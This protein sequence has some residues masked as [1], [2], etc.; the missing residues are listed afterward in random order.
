MAAV[1]EASLTGR[2]G[3]VPWRAAERCLIVGGVTGG[4]LEAVALSH[5]PL[6]QLD[7]M[8]SSALA[9]APGG[10]ARFADDAARWAPSSALEKRLRLR[11]GYKGPLLFFERLEAL[12]HAA[13][14]PG[15]ERPCALLAA[16][17]SGEWADEALGAVSPG[18]PAFARQLDF[19]H[20]LGPLWKAFGWYLGLRDAW[21]EV[22][23]LAAAGSP[24]FAGAISER[25]LDL[26]RDGSFRL[27]MGYFAFCAGLEPVNARFGALFG[28][29][30]RRA[31]E[32]PGA[33]EADVAASLQAVTVEVLRRM[34]AEARRQAG[35]EDLCLVGAASL[36]AAAVAALR[37]DGPGQLYLASPPAPVAA[38]VGAAAAA[39][40]RALQRGR[41]ELSP[42]AWFLP[43]EEAAAV[44]AFE[45]ERPALRL[46]GFGAAAA[47]LLLLVAGHP[48]PWIAGFELGLAL[49][50]ALGAW[51]A[52]ETL[53][54]LAVAAG[55]ACAYFLALTPYSLVARTLGSEFLEER[56]RAAG[57]YWKDRRPE[58]EGLRALRRPF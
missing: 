23:A 42:S 35:A 22:P 9:Y 30:P 36:N 18:E 25:L 40:S 39:W 51:R 47:A 3:G 14:P 52:P 58:G 32:A 54:E 1:S 31:G 4:H 26:K 11:L 44:D 43:V 46:L 19:P 6:L 28:G 45:L 21:S 48:P 38:A 5:K 24:R 55:L 37:A 33:R 27:D 56:W 7:R 29:G 13:L 17:A 20:G 53:G 50:C 57:T 34:A 2:P 16:G 10:W 15:A 41:P 49:V 12:A 8:L